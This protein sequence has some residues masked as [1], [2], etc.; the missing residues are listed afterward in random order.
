MTGP[1]LSKKSSKR[2]SFKQ[3]SKTFFQK[4]YRSS[5]FN[6]IT[7]SFMVSLHHRAVH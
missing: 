6:M 4:A 7:K 1:Q 5:F 3:L 2:V